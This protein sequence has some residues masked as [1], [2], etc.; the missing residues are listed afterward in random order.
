MSNLPPD[1]GNYYGTCMDCGGRYHAS[2]TEQCDCEE[3]ER[4]EE[5]TAPDSLDEKGIC[6]TCWKDFGTCCPGCK[7]W[8]LDA[9]MEDGAC[10]NC[11]NT[12][13][14]ESH[15]DKGESRPSA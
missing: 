12:L 5:T 14:G 6:D 4:C 11:T 7:E 10:P 2:G 13:E 1:W 8:T 9:S 15:E 3:C